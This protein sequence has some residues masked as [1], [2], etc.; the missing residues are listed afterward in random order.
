MGG[1]HRGRGLYHLICQDAIDAILIKGDHPV[2][3][4]DLIVSHLTILDVP[5]VVRESGDG[6]IIQLIVC[7]QI[8]ILICLGETMATVGGGR[9]GGG[10]KEVGVLTWRQTGACVSPYEGS[11][12]KEESPSVERTA[13]CLQEC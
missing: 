3:T 1:R 4:S 8:L 11:C 2:E 13:S 12:W 6:H 7:Q 9:G 5:R 10:E